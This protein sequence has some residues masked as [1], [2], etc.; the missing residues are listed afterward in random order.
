[1]KKLIFFLTLISIFSCS[2]ERKDYNTV[3][4]G[5]VS[6][7]ENNAYIAD[8]SL[9]IKEQKAELFSWSNNLETLKTDSLGRFEFKFEARENYIYALVSA[10]NIDFAEIYYTSIV[11]GKT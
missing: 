7:A 1:M 11:V 10:D 6:N 5:T 2:K 8:Y 3:V 9:T 4:K